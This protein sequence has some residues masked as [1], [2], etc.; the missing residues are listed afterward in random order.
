MLESLLML[1]MDTHI[2]ADAVY[3]LRQ[4]SAGTHAEDALPKFATALAQE[5]DH[6]PRMMT[7]V[8]WQN[9]EELVH[10]EEFQS[11]RRE[12]LAELTELVVDLVVG[13][14][15]P[16]HRRAWEARAYGAG[17]L[18]KEEEVYGRLLSVLLREWAA[19]FTTTEA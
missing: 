16:P 6:N 7:N 2:L 3:P 12:E 8:I 9:L 17:E 15:V 19:P 4:L 13:R 11:Q 1:S 14:S 10:T 18:I 5:L